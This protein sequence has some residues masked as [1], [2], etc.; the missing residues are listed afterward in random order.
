[1]TPDDAAFLGVPLGTRDVFEPR[2][3]VRCQ[4]TG[5]LGRIAA[6]EMFELDEDVRERIAGGANEKAIARSARR[7]TTLK[8]DAA[9]K[10]LDGLTTVDEVR[11]IVVLES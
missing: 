11:R 4:R 5:F 10:V 2:G 3:C 6:F 7:L 9:L 1:M 8:E